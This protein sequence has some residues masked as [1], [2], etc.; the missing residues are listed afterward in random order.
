MGKSEE[1][2]RTKDNPQEIFRNLADKLTEVMR[3]RDAAVADLTRVCNAEVTGEEIC[4]AC[5]HGIDCQ[6]VLECELMR[7]DE[8]DGLVGECNFKW[9]GVQREPAPGKEADTELG[10]AIMRT[11]CKR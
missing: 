1:L 7:Y 3:E 10:R 9:R 8:N 4:R 2:R 5:A 11:I 6:G